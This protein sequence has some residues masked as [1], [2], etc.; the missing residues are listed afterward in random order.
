MI[1]VIY[2]T[3]L[4]IQITVLYILAMCGKSTGMD[5]LGACCVCNERLLCDE[6]LF[7]FLFFGIVNH[8]QGINQVI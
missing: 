7:L 6:I 5:V 8:L 1:N 4:A 3:V 2:R